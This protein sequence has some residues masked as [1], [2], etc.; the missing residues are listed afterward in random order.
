MALP[1]M[2]AAAKRLL[3]QGLTCP[4]YGQ[5]AYQS[6]ESNIDFESRYKYTQV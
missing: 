1:R 5:R 6:Y 4:G 2:I 3:E